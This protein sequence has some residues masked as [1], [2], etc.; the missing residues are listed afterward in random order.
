MPRRSH[1][2]RL[3]GL[4]PPYTAAQISAWVALVASYAQFIVFITPVLPL[5]A[6]ITVTAYFTV[7]VGAVV[8]FGV[9]T[10]LLDP[11]DVHLA[12]NWKNTAPD[13]PYFS[14]QKTLLNT[15]YQQNNPDPS[16]GVLPH[17][18]MKQCWICDTMVADHSMHCKFC[19]K[20]VY[21]FDHHCM[22]K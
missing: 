21:H 17:E 8:Y 1:S 14:Q 10:Q 7:V 4:S 9:K 16:L 15:L 22:C 19:N 3:N 20:C 18:E 5:I 2:R 6:A 11:I 13:P 12:T